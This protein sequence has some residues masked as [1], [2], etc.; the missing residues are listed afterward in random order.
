MWNIFIRVECVQR[1][2]INQGKVSL[3]YGLRQIYY[4]FFR[5]IQISIRPHENYFHWNIFASHVD[6]YSRFTA[7]RI[8]H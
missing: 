1:G 7:Y 3:I 5:S 4:I 2:K 6:V 8:N